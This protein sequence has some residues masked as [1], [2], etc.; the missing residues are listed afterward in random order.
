M[1]TS[2][3]RQWLEAGKTLAVD[4]S[5][6]VRCPEKDDGFLTVNDVPFPGDPSTVERYLVCETCG[7]R[8]V[9]R[10]RVPPKDQAR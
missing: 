4:P 10:M 2:K 8:N 1:T 7:A 5:A 6:R 9:L 3:V